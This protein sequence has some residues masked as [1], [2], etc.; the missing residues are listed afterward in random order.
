MKTTILK[1]VKKIIKNILFAALAALLVFSCIGF[2]ACRQKPSDEVTEYKVTYVDITEDNKVLKTEDV[3]E[4]NKATVWTPEKE[5]YTFVQWYATPDMLHVFDFD[6]AIMQ[7]TTVYGYFTSAAF[8]EDTRTFYILGSSSDENSVLYGTSYKLTNET[9]QKLVK[10]DKNGSNEY[11]ITLDL[12]LGDAFQIA[13]ND[14][15]ENQRGYGYLDAAAAEGYFGGKPNFLDPNPR[16]ADIVVE[17]AGNYTFTLTTHPWSDAYE[18]DHASYSEEKK[19]NFNFNVED[20]ISFVRNGDPIVAPSDAPLEIYVK[21]AYITGWQHKTSQEFTMVYDAEKDVYTYSHEFVAGD[22]FMFYNFTKYLGEDNKWHNTLGS[23]CLNTD[24]VDKEQSDV[25]ALELKPSSNI[26]AKK[27]GTYSFVYDRNTDKLTIK[28]D[29]AFT[30]GYTPADTWYISGSGITEPLK[31]SAF[32]NN[33]TDSQK[34]SKESAYLFKITLDLARG[35][36]F[37]IVMN[38][39]YGGQHGYAN[40]IDPVKDNISYFALAGDGNNARVEVSGN[41][42]LTLNLDKD[43]PLNDTI[44]WVRNGDIIQTLPV[45]YDVFMKTQPDEGSTWIISERHSTG[46][47]GMKEGIVEFRAFFLAGKQFCFIYY[48]PGVKAEEVGSYFNPGMLISGAM[49][50]TDGKYNDNFGVFENNF[51]CNVQGFYV[52][53]VDFNGGEVKVDFVGY[54]EAM[55]EFEAVIKGPANDGTWNNSQR[56]ASKNGKTEMILKLSKGEFGFT[57]YGDAMDPQYGDYVGFD[58]IGAN[59]NANRLFTQPENG[60]NNIVCTVEGTYKIVIDY[61]TGAPVV[62]FYVPDWEVIVKGSAFDVGWNGTDRLPSFG[63]RFELE[64][65]FIEGGEFGFAVFGDGA[66]PKYGDYVGWRYMGKNGDANQFFSQKGNGNN[67]VCNKG[68]RY[69]IVIDFSGDDYVLDFYL[70]A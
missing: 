68:G 25:E 16:K 1:D 13:I 45:A 9:A 51:V 39:S 29:S 11:S 21:G 62:D 30:Q 34:L 61:S 48:E 54:Q 56:Y 43:T 40:I 20:T 18:T 55:P 5:G 15:F 7:D 57:L 37:Q 52:M 27:S 31:S 24:T 10:T 66:D 3:A 14:S 26:A 2:V 69:K 32:G 28:Y 60:G 59:G 6:K 22:N 49:I 53:R 41:Y 47:D 19:E 42:T 65:D 17:R 44:T 63:S 35:D 8:E 33:L 70:V 4:G 64:Y 12:Y 36:L 46:A 38:G 50:G 67:I 23:V 58:K